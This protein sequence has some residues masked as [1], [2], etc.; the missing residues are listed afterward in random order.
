MVGREIY[1]DTV[2]EAVE[3]K[4]TTTVSVTVFKKRRQRRQ[5]IIKHTSQQE[6]AIWQPAWP[7]R[8]TRVSTRWAQQVG[9]DRSLNVDAVK[10][11]RRRGGA[12][13]RE[14]EKKEG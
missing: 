13:T 11:T 6:L 5:E 14:P 8:I 10:P 1:L 3:L 12:Q 4:Q 9:A 2:L 7:T